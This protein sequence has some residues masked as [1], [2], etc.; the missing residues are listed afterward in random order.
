MLPSPPASWEGSLAG[1]I[2]VSVTVSGRARLFGAPLDGLVEAARIADAVGIDPIAMPDQLA[3]GPRTDR[4]P[5]GRFPFPAEEPWLEP[6]T[7]LAAVAGATC[8]TRLATGVLLAPLRPA[9]L[10]AKTLASL[11]VRSAGRG[12]LRPFLERLGRDRR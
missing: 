5:H 2:A 8:R 10:L 7:I 3:I 9:L 1:S 11:D 6:L 12:A 4:Y